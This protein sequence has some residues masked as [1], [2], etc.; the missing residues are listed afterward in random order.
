MKYYDVD[1]DG[2][3]GYE[4]FLNG[5]RDPL[6]PRKQAIVDRAFS[7]LDKTGSGM[8]Q[9][10]DV[11]KLYDTSRHPAVIEGKKTHDQVLQEFLN[12]FEGLQGNRD[13]IISK[14]EWDKYYTNLGMSVPSDEYFVRMM[15]QVW[16][17]S[18]DESSGVFEDEV[19][20]VIGLIRQRLLTISGD[21]TEEFTL[22]K[23][24]NDFDLNE[25]GSITVDELAAMIAK[26]EVSVE[27]KY[28]NGIMKKFDTNNTSMIEFD[29]FVNVLV[30]DPY[31]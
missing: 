14:E 11:T 3:I 5:L 6:N 22:R 24:F 27:R 13:G 4:E 9:A 28:I 12:S 10:S 1:G 8:I 18:E 20:R 25:S 26:L 7:L 17:I 16:A 15:E 31:K 2:N 30:N 21:S 19:R 23:I 29:E